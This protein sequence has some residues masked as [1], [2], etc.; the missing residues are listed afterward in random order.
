MA[1]VSQESPKHRK[2]R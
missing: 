2:Q 1:E